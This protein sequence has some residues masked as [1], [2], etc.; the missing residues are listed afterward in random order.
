MRVVVPMAG[1]G[2]RFIAAGYA[3]PKPLVRIDGR[4]VIEHLL[5]QFPSS[6]PKTFICNRTHLASSELG[7]TLERLAPGCSIVAIEPHKQGPVF[8]VLEAARLMPEALPDEEPCLINYCDFNFS[9]DPQRFVA[10]A[11]RT[12]CDGAVFCYTG[13]HPEYAR[14]TLYAYCRERQGHL[15]EIKEKAHFTA[16]RTQ[17]FASSGTYYFARFALA[18]RSFARLMHQG[19]LVA[20]EGYVSLAYN[21]LIEEGLDVRVFEIPWFMQWGTPADVADY[22]YWSGV[23]SRYLSPDPHGATSQPKRPMQLLMPMAG[24]GSRFGAGPPK[25]LR[26]V[27]GQAMFR[28]ALAHLPRAGNLVLVVQ[29]QHAATVGA[30]APQARVISVPTP[31]DGQASTCALGCSALAADEPVLVSSCDHGLV[32][33]EARW[34]ALL[35][36]D[37]DVVVW[38]QRNY[39]GTEVTP[40]AFAYFAAEAGRVARVS[41]KKPLSSQPRRDLLLVGTFYFKRPKLLAE[42][43]AELRARDLRVNG[44]LYLD[45]VIDLAIARGLAVRSFEAD[46]YLC[47]GTP[48]ALQQFE[49]WHGWFSGQAA[50]SGKR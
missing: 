22:E 25:F 32:W 49:Y 30:L 4:P 2:G 35:D 15:L 13:Y 27:L 45:S 7:P 36:S 26:Q 48:E 44:E 10:F 1:M 16:D 38:G 39:P 47:W 46:G 37:P 6:W 34:Q 41:V 9:W 11:E 33:D 42:L 12:R 28:A 17:E 20:G 21:Q 50:P 43:V 8:S 3:E 14:P 23:C 19:P 40:E 24:R 31:T 5:A 18:R 29:E